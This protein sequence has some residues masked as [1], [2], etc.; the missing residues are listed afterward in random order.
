MSKPRQPATRTPVQQDE[1]IVL[2]SRKYLSLT[3]IEILDLLSEGEIEGLVEGEYSF[4]GTKGNLGYT[5]YTYTPYEDPAGIPGYKWLRSIYWNEVPV[6]NSANKFNFQRVDVSKTNGYTQGALLGG[7]INTTTISRIINERLRGSEID[8]NGDPISADKDYAKYYRILNTSCVGVIVNVKITRLGESDPSTGDASNSLLQYRIYYR[9]LYGGDEAQIADYSSPI[10]ENVRGYITQGYVH[11]SYILFNQGLITANNFIGWEIKVVRTTPDTFS[12]YKSNQSYID[13]LTEIYNDTLS[14]P[15]SALVRA[16][17]SAEYFAQIPSRAFDTR[18]LK[19]KIP[20]N[21]DPIKR[22]YATTGPGTTNGVWDGSFAEEKYWSDNPAWCFYDLLTN[23]TYGL[24]RYIE[25]YRI[26][27]FTLY[28]IAQYCDILVPDGKGGVEPQFTCNLLLSSKEE[29]YKVINDM[30]SVFNG[31][32]YYANSLI[33]VSQDKPKNAIVHFTNSNVQDGNFSYSSSAKK[34][35]RTVARVRWNDPA[36]YFKP[37]IEYVENINGIR[38]YGIREVEV[39][40]FG[41]TSQGQA[42]RLGRWMLASELGETETVSFRTGLEGAMLHPGDIF[43]VFDINRKKYKHSGRARS[44]SASSITLDAKYSYAYPAGNYIFKVIT[45]TYNYDPAVVDNLTSSETDDIRRSFIQER[46]ISQAAITQ[47][48]DGYMV[49][50]LSTPLDTINYNLIDNAVWSLEMDPSQTIDTTAFIN[51][52]KDY[53][54]VIRVEEK[55]GYMYD[56]AAIQYLESKFEEVTE[57]LALETPSAV[58]NY[59]PNGPLAIILNLIDITRN[60]K[61]IQYSFTPPAV[62]TGITQYKIFAKKGAFANASPDTAYL[63]NTLPLTTF[64]SSFAPSEAG[65]WYVRVYS[66]NSNTNTYS[67]NYVESS[68]SVTNIDPILDVII[69]SLQIKDYEGTVTSSSSSKD[70][71]TLTDENPQFDWQVGFEDGAPAPNNLSY[72]LTIRPTSATNIPSPTIY[73]EVTG[74]NINS[75]IFDI[76]TNSAIAGGPYSAFDVVVEAHN[77]YGSTSAGN[78]INPRLENGWATNPEGYDIIYASPIASPIT[79][80]NLAFTSTGDTGK[81]ISY[82]DYNGGVN[83]LFP[84]GFLSTGYAGGYIYG[85]TGNF[86]SE[87]ARNLRSGIARRRFDWDSTL[88]TANAPAVFNIMQKFTTGYT[89]ISFY[90]EFDAVRLERGYEIA[91]GLA[92]SN[93]IPIFASGMTNFLE[94]KGQIAF[95]HYNGNIDTDNMKMQISST[96]S[97]NYRLVATNPAGQEVIIVSKK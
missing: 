73:H 35:R 42:N 27:K 54:R 6:V 74:L 67:T 84:S 12:V 69:T 22:T 46:T 56:V 77:E 60:S 61:Q 66:Y 75:Y 49:I 65:L 86:D 93:T 94:V 41:C 11:S 68:I 16:K 9:P 81:F 82:I 23:K 15:K 89:A 25:D 2:N 40:A 5:S 10:S 34:A 76:D 83:Y 78:T 71:Q 39:T 92:I 90:N 79:S 14:Y 21:Y 43:S 24:G 62:T 50:T 28:K 59:T 17:F 36:N 38:K 1:G 8:G 45:P 80:I 95:P 3:E 51:E 58:I 87:S 29:A 33:Y 19:I 52:D 13:S 37:T 96:S 88:R 30:A 85:H 64:V 20:A 91:S 97:S 31:M 53:Y 55:E 44:I 70:T 47:N 48:A 63:I 7:S 4:V 32:T 26:D 57:G 18:L 72:R